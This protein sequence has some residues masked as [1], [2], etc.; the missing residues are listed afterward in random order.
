MQRDAHHSLVSNTTAGNN[1]G[2][3]M[4]MSMS[5]TNIQGIVFVWPPQQRNQQYTQY[6]MRIL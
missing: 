5:A 2:N 6:E 1:I 4:P 3:C